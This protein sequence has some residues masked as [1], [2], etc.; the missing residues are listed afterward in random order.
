MNNTNCEQFSR[1]FKHA[2]TGHEKEEK[3][4]MFN[5]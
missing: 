4:T 2:V 3:R 5:V 1:S